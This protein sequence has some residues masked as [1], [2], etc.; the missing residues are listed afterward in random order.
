MCKI[1]NSFG[2]SG[3]LKG[4]SSNSLQKP[5]LL[6]FFAAFNRFFFVT[7][8]KKNPAKDFLQS[9]IIEPFYNSHSLFNA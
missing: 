2:E 8:S 3:F 9:N 1:D 5:G 7:N 4:F 6:H